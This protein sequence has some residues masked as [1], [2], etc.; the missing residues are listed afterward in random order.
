MLQWFA[1]LNQVSACQI[2]RGRPVYLPY[3]LAAR[4]PR[5]VSRQ[6]RSYGRGR[7]LQPEGGSHLDQQGP[8]FSPR[9][10]GGVG[11]PHRRLPGAGQIPQV[12][13]GPH[14]LARRGHPPRRRGRRP[15][16]HHRPDDPDRRRLRGGFPAHGINGNSL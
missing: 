13:Q 6:G 9:A 5:R 10:A 7:A 4:R 1:F 3:P 16:L 11:L 15:R 12:A 14:P 8:V 2:E